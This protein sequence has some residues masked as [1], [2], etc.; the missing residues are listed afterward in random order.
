MQLRTHTYDAFRRHARTYLEPAIIHKLTEWQ[1]QKLKMLSEAKSVITGGD[2]G[3]DSPEQRGGGKLIHGEGGSYKKLGPPTWKWCE[4]QKFLRERK[5][6]HYY[7]IWHLSKK[8]DQLGKDK[9]CALV[10]KWHK[11]IVNHLYWFATSSVH[12]TEKVA[13]WK[14]LL[15]HIQDVHILTQ[16]STKCVYPPKASKDHSKWF[17]PTLNRLDK[18]LTNKRNLTDV[19]KLSHHFQLWIHSTVSSS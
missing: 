7:D 3:A 13:K 15:N 17:Q 4:I 1:I 19:E 9:D 14:S 11:N 10:K 16:P 12:G 5:I 2:V 18:V 6:T 8:L